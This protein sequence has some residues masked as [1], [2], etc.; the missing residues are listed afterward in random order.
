MGSDS[1][2]K[3]EFGVIK[4]TAAYIGGY[5]PQVWENGSPRMSTY[6]GRGRDRELAREEAEY[7]AN[8]LATRYIGDW[9][10]TIEERGSDAHIQ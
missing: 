6:S 5:L 3:I 4:N 8:E 2:I 9:T 1:H 10:I 7:R